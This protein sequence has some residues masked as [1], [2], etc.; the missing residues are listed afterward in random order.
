MIEGLWS[1]V[2][3]PVSGAEDP[4][5]LSYR[6]RKIVNF[7]R[8]SFLHG[9][10]FANAPRQNKHSSSIVPGLAACFAHSLPSTVLW[11]LQYFLTTGQQR[12]SI[13]MTARV[14]AYFALFRTN[15]CTP[16]AEATFEAE[17]DRLAQHMKWE[18]ASR[19]YQRQLKKAKQKTQFQSTAAATSAPPS[20]S[21]LS[22]TSGVRLLTPPTTDCEGTTAAPSVVSSYFSSFIGD[23]SRL[24]HQHL[25]KKISSSCPFIQAGTAMS[26]LGSGLEQLRASWSH[27]SVPW[28]S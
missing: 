21:A 18:P 22:E 3:G 10:H 12:K 26:E 8:V 24:T 5:F 16:K 17:F 6:A 15:G 9:P 27:S 2:F 7:L 19:A 13:T 28:T 14:D 20:T 25:S 23:D 11:R 4:F 1:D